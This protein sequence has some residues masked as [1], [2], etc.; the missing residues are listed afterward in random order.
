MQSQTEANNLMLERG[1]AS[2]RSYDNGP[3]LEAYYHRE[4][5]MSDPSNSI[6]GSWEVEDNSTDTYC[7][8]L[9]LAMYAPNQVI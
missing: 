8:P 7:W 6:R 4:P 5:D 3:G 9:R 2:N 1:K